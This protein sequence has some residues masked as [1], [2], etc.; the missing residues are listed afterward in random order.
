MKHLNEARRVLDVEIRA[1]KSAK[2]QL[3]RSFDAAV[4]LIL[5][6]LKNRGKVVVAG[7]GKSGNVCSK[8]SATFAS[9]GTSSVRLH[10]ADALHGDLGVVGDGDCAVMISYSGETEELVNLLPAMKRLGVAIVLITGGLRSTLAKHSDVVLHA[11]VPQEACPFNLAPT[12][13]TTVA[14]ALGDALAMAVLKARGFSRDDFARLHPSGSIGRSLLLKVEDVMRTASASPRCDQREKVQVALKKMT[15]AKAGSI[16]VTGPSGR[17][18]GIFTHGDFVRHYQKN[19]MVG[20]ER[21]G[22]V[23]TK[24]P[25]TVRIGALATEAL[26]IFQERRIDDLLVVN[27]RKE[28]VGLIDSQDLAKLKIV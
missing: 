8:I 2:T 19:P 13:S 3:D 23:M 15:Q 21:I 7:M 27:A 6:T 22:R 10:P 16:A 12:S 11:R 1:L 18:A 25:V 24:N 4:E 14:M 28:P 9:T 5:G 20:E 17:L 26:R